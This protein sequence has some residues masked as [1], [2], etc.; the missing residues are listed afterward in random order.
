MWLVLALW[1]ATGDEA[2]P[3][4][5]IPHFATPAPCTPAQANEIV[6]CARRVD[7]TRYRVAAG[8]TQE[9]D[10][11]PPQAAVSIGNARL[12]AEGRSVGQFNAPAAT[13]TIRVPF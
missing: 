10:P 4:F 7:P 8:P 5:V 11:R 3:R 9:A 2:T 1:Q 6:I 13:I 12:S